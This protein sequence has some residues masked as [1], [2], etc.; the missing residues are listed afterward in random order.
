MALTNYAELKTG[1]RNWLHRTNLTERIPEF[2]ALAEAK[3]NR[4]AQVQAM[5]KE[6]SLVFAPG[7]RSAPLPAGFTSP[8]AAWL[9]GSPPA[10]LVGRVPEDMPRGDTAG[11]PSFWCI[12]G[13]TLAVDRPADVTRT[14]TLRYRGG[15]TLTDDNPTNAVLTKYPDLYLY[16][17][18]LQAAPYIRNA[19]D[20]NVWQAFYQ[21]AVLE[22]NQTESRARAAAPLRTELTQVLRRGG[23]DITRGN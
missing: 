9:D 23:F 4:I 12:D 1:I 7:A 14:V 2:I 21:S 16:G 15:F 6:A 5:E 10:Q 18:L 19:Q 3:I 13:T 22:V 8:I 17:A 20:F 11:A